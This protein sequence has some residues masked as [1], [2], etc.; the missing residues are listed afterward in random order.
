[1]K[2]Y[3]TNLGKYNDGYLIGK[4]ID[5]PIDKEE[6]KEVLEERDSQEIL[7]LKIAKRTFQIHLLQ[8]NKSL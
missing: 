2:G 1:M 4:W 5:F 8:N 6:L 7:K 3:I